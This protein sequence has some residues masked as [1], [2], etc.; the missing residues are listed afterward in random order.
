MRP[1]VAVPILVLLSLVLP[2]CDKSPTSA[3][4]SLAPAATTP[5]DAVRLLQWSYDRRDFDR[6]RSVFTSD[7]R[8]RFFQY[9]TTGAAYRA[10]P[11][12]RDDELIAT[13]RLFD[14][15]A[16]I[17]LVVEDNN[18]SLSRDLRPGRNPRWHMVVHLPIHLQA[19]LEDGSIYEVAGSDWFAC[20]RGD[21]A[22]IPAD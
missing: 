22:M 7:F 8:F 11:W 16:E 14:S 1:I 15:A 4:E 13:R 9:D 10:V 5:L 19:R 3:P 21:S 20:T 17:R 18:Y 6:Y 2:G 12:T